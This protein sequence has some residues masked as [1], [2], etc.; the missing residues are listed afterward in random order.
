MFRRIWSLF[1]KYAA[2]HATLKRSGFPLWDSN[3][4]RIGHIDHMTVREGR[5]GVEGWAMSKL[6][7]LTNS[8]QMQ[9]QVP[10]LV[11]EDVSALIDDSGIETPG[12]ALDIT[13]QIDH[14]VVWIEVGSTRY[15]YALPQLTPR[16]L[17]SVRMAQLIPFM[18]DG[19]RA[20]PAVLHWL[21]HRDPQSVARVKTTLGL[22]T[23]V[24]SNQ[25]NE[26]LFSQDVEAEDTPPEAL[27]LTGITIILPV[28][29]AL[30]LLPEVLQRVVDHT[31]L[32]WRLIVI[33]D[34]SSDDQVRPW[35][36]NWHAGLPSET[37]SCVTLIEN[38]TNLGFIRSVNKAFATALPFG[39]H[40]VLL[41]SDAFVP[42]GW[43]SRLIRPL[44]EHDNVASVTPMS[45]DAEIFNAPVI[46]QREQLQPGEADLID[47]TAAEFFPGADLGD[48]P[49]GVGFCMAMNIEYLRKLPR[50]D[51]G[52]G[53]GYGEEVDWSQR[54]R[55]I[56]GRHLGNAGLFVEHRG[57]TSFGSS[58]KQKLIRKNGEVI[59]RR[60][61]RYDA[62]VQD[63][64]RLDPLNT[65][66]LALAI[67][68]A[69]AR[70]GGAV[71]VYLAHSM[72][73]G[74]E[75]YLQ[76]RIKGD[77]ETGTTAVILRVGGSSRWQIE[78]HNLHGVTQ[79]R[80]DK[81]EFVQRL[82]GIL[83]VRKIVYSCAVGDRDPI[84]LPEILISLAS[85]SEDRIE[86][87]MHDFLPLSPSYILLDSDGVYRGVP[88]PA[89]QDDV[90]HCFSRP[91][92]TISDLG[93]WR[94]SWGA[95]L[96]AAHEIVVFSENSHSL[97]S[98]A[99][100]DIIDK[101]KVTP[102]RL[103]TDVPKVQPGHVPD[104]VP[105]IGVL[106]NIGYQKGITVLRDLSQLLAKNRKA[107]LVII[108][109]IDPSYKLAS[110]V[111]VHGSY[112][113]EE[114]PSLVARYGIICWLIPSIWP[115][116]FSYTT[117]EALATGLPV[118]SFDL[119]AQGDAARAAAE[120]CGQGGVI[121]LMGGDFDLNEML[122][123]MMTNQSHRKDVA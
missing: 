33:E 47:K 64:I 92:G 5:L 54:A 39:D 110:S 106:G 70:H 99:Y 53:R 43:A 23:V 21:I 27:P 101:L 86:V 122:E 18:R 68:W 89:S 114:I 96:Q 34:C 88:M 120:E 60:Y 109:N 50:F 75:I 13:L 49:T 28:Y 78:V 82:L 87:L 40:V 31:D 104:G 10:N 73:G 15:V 77:L 119:G 3:G 108:G 79:G 24:P 83:P 97:V 52:F 102:H 22:N 32:P 42:S 51:T 115:E 48:A 14:T 59:S 38:E 116:T 62:D 55:R 90:V 37:A 20:F 6:V 107:R 41:N 105:V 100:P 72:G 113:V 118:W 56:G 8:S 111:Q 112:H 69:G 17:F 35:L 26:F 67:A 12:F 76:N 91:D 81:T 84:S 46:C 25:L 45:N 71:P 29:N 63:F 121:P 19:A 4:M 94:A 65:P 61:P 93:R 2:H 36:R 44:L 9:Q 30:D 123:R 1:N 74:A 16:E 117:H 57:G 7:G 103:V 95:L 58:E 80:T 98:Q 11:R 66:R 85:G